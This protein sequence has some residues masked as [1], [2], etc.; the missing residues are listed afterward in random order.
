MCEFHNIKKWREKP[1]N[2]KQGS[3]DQIIIDD[4]LFNQIQMHNHNSLLLY[5]KLIEANVAPEQARAVLPLN[6]YTNCICSG[7]LFAFA[8]VCNLRLDGHAQEETRFVAEEINYYCDKEFPHCWT[9]L[10]NVKS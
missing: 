7:T 5:N 6:T 10:L 3:G 4:E 1:K 2:S 8:R 9:H